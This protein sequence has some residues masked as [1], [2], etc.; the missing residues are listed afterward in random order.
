MLDRGA[1][2]HHDREPAV[3]GDPRGL[4]VDD[5]ELEPEAM[6]P[7][8]DRLTGMGLAEL[9]AA[10]Y[11]DEVERAG[12]ANSLAQRPERRYPEDR[13][14]RGVHGHAVVAL[15]DEVAKDAE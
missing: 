4:P 2:V 5:A 6:C 8:L 1:A 9:G 3:V 12:R 13:A 10:E 15:V 14:L 11:I 7:D